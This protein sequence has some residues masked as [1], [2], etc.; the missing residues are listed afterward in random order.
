MTERL[1][2]AMAQM[3]DEREHRS[4]HA[5]ARAL[6][7][8]RLAVSL[9]EGLAHDAGRNGYAGDDDNAALI[10]AFLDGAASPAE[11]DAIAAK[12][13]GD[14]AARADLLSAMALLDN[15]AAQPEEPPAG[16]A[17]RAAEI[18]TPAPAP[19]MQAGGGWMRSLVA[20]SRWR[21]APG[22]RFALAAVL[23][24]AI[25]TPAVLQVAWRGDG[26]QQHEGDATGGPVGRGLA[27]APATLQKTPPARAK[28]ST[29]K[30]SNGC[31]PS[32]KPAVAG[33]P[34]AERKTPPAAAAKPM[35]NG[36]AVP[37]P[38]AQNDPCARKPPAAQNLPAGRRN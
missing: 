27:P 26:A 21:Q 16:L 1:S 12:L 37:S 19:A 23:M 17:A 32:E 18:F 15:I 38:T 30:E 20:A 13:V 33:E 7:H 28:E 4:D 10:A 35:M 22:A 3:L 29:A 6:L 31:E 5:A 8:A 24:V 14:P 34:P 9:S 25:A 2:E 11:C 36:A